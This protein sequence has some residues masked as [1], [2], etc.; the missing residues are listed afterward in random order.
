ME[1]NNPF[2]RALEVR[3]IPEPFRGAAVDVTDT[4]NLAKD[5]AEAVFGAKATPEHAIAIATLMLEA[6]G[7]IR[8]GTCNRPCCAPRAD[9]DNP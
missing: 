9:S 7:R 8:Q 3:R 5:A 4:V 2:D 1:L 6:A